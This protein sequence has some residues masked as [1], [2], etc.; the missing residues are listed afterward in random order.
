MVMGNMA[1]MANRATGKNMDMDM[2]MRN[3]MF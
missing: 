1:S 3:N 2:D